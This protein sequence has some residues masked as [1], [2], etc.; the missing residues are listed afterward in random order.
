M[1]DE[2]EK[3]N[4]RTAMTPA[5]RKVPY[6]LELL[7]LDS[8]ENWLS[9][10]TME[11]KETFET[12]KQKFSERYSEN[13]V[14]KHSLVLNVWEERQ[15][16]N[17]S[18]DDNYD[19]H[20]KLVKLAGLTADAN[21][22][23]AFVHGLLPHFR[24]QVLMQRKVELKDL[25]EAARLAEIAFRETGETPL[26]ATT[27]TETVK[28]KVNKEQETTPNNQTIKVLMELLESVVVATIG[29]TAST[30]FTTPPNL[31]ESTAVQVIESQPD[32]DQ[33]RQHENAQ[34]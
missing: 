8:A 32:H 22:N 3:K 14:T 2:D 28:M 26:A 27:I 24:V 30:T 9:G 15:K 31:R 4:I 19:R 10:L 12:F 20:V 29:K 16:P 23:Q 7:L 21:T 25:L 5:K 1:T 6:I 18:V 17:D 34:N 11:E 13:R 33:R